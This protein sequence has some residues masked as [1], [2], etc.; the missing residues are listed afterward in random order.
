[1]VDRDV[2]V[3]Q[4][5]VMHCILSLK[6]HFIVL[7]P[8]LSVTLF[9]ILFLNKQI[10]HGRKIVSFHFSLFI[11][12]RAKCLSSEQCVAALCSGCSLQQYLDR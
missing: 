5:C 7:I 3:L 1:M 12:G 8:R 9:T 11:C 10:R 4:D 6:L 2:S